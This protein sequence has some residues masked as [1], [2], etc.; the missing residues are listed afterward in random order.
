M[1]EKKN[2]KSAYVKIFSRP[3]SVGKEDCQRHLQLNTTS[4]N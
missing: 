4:C 1:A 2:D 3:V